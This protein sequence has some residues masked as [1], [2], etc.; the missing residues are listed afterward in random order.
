M[1]ADSRRLLRRGGG[2]TP[3]LAGGEWRTP[4]LASD[5]PSGAPLLDERA[6]KGEGL[7]KTHIL[8]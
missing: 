2:S 3:N 4:P 1:R 8:S 5:A 6:S 7:L